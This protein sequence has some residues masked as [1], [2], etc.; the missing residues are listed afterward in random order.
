MAKWLDD[1]SRGVSTV[2][3]T[4]QDVL[5]VVRQVEQ[6]GQPPIATPPIAAQTQAP[7]VTAPA[8]GGSTEGLILVGVVVVIALVL[9]R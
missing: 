6:L 4:A 3:D 7:V 8:A 9:L 1:L 2:M 5:D